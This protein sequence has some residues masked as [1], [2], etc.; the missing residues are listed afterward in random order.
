M[1]GRKEAKAWIA[2]RWMAES[3]FSAFKCIFGEHV[4]AVRWKNMVREPMLKTS[5]YKC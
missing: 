4:R 3:A 2:Y 1:D 5:I